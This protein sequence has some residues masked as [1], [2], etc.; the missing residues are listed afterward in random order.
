MRTR[1]TLVLAL[2]AGL[3]APA[4][5]EDA[6]AEA[7]AA[8]DA[9]RTAI[10]GMTTTPEGRDQVA[11]LTATV[12]AY[13]QG[14]ASL[15]A[16]LRRAAIRE[17]EIRSAFNDRSNRLGRILGVMSAMEQ[18][19]E[20]LLLLHPSGPEGTARAGMLLGSVAPAIQAEADRLKADLAEIAAVRAQQT[21]AE[22]VLA[23]GLGRVQA[24]RQALAQ[25][26]ADRGDLPTRFVD[27]P[28]EL[29]RMV[30]AARTLDD[31]AQ[32]LAGLEQDVGAPMGDFEGAKGR[33]PMPVIGTVLR[34]SGQPDAAG[35][36]RPGI[37][38]AT[39]PAAMV[40]APWPVTIRYRG[41]LLDYGNVMIVE[42]ARDYLLIL[43][44]LSVVFGQTGDVLAA[45]EPLGLMGG[46]EPTAA[47]F[48]SGFVAAAREG[49]GAGRTETLYIEL[50]KGKTPI[51]P[52]P[53]FAPTGKAEE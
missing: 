5:A 20:T 43:A 50:R 2:L 11:A 48:G 51:D 7:R 23:S 35:I 46:T 27:Q 42:P 33:L 44:G 24:A 9:L 53:W 31:F 8:A 3:A 30:A 41:P 37:V 4:R 52:E 40:T 39:A 6:A 45:G 13:E 14:L 28:E 1:L 15:R 18:S 38:V 32:G 19:P 21:E 10:E 47:E 25:A 34:G 16:G 49:G 12:Q 22:A 36:S 29:T 26:I 17:A